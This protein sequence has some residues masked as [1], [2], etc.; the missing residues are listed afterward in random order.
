MGKCCCFCCSCFP[1]QKCVALGSLI[2]CTC[3]FW[4]GMVGHKQLACDPAALLPPRHPAASAPPG[5]PRSAIL[6]HGPHGTPVSLEDGSGLEA[7][8]HL[9]AASRRYRPCPAG[10]VPPPPPPP[11]QQQHQVGEEDEDDQQEAGGLADA[12]ADELAEEAEEGA[13]EQLQQA[14]APQAVQLRTLVDVARRVAPVVSAFLAGEAGCAV[15]SHAHARHLVCLLRLGLCSLL[16]IRDHS[17]Q[18]LEEQVLPV[19]RRDAETAAAALLQQRQA[20]SPQ[21]AAMVVEQ[22]HV[23]QQAAQQAAA[24]EAAQQQ[25]AQQAAAMQA[26][27]QAA[28]MQA[29]AAAAIVHQQQQHHAIGMS[30]AGDP[31]VRGSAAWYAYC[32][33]LAE[34][35][36]RMI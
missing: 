32:D 8:L 22:Q 36:F 34:D 7:K 28:A 4:T 6:R 29:A 23:A 24:M 30:W 35:G 2:S 3:I 19:L 13:G 14:A 9:C 25:A 15:G 20:A 26:A 12:V 33:A 27:Q 10:T 16:R 5:T 11:Q 17:R 21:A 1:K 31:N 18:E